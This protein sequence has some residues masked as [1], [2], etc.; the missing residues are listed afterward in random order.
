MRFFD[1]QASART[2]SRRLLLAFALAVAATVLA[3]HAA[4]WLVWGGLSILLLGRPAYPTLFTEV[5]LALALL[6]VLGGWWLEVSLLGQSAEKLARRLG[7]RELR[8]NVDFAEQRLANV[9]REMA[10]AAQMRPPRVMLLPRV[11]EINA[12]AL[13]RQPADWLVVVSAGALEWLSRRELQGLVAHEL[14]HLKEDDTR[15][16]LQLAG[17]VGGLEMV[18]NYGGWVVDKSLPDNGAGHSQGVHLWH[19]WLIG[20]VIQAAGWVG[21][22]IG[23]L[24][25]AAVSREREYL[26]DA[27]AVQWTRD[28]EGL[29]GVLRKAWAQH[30]ARSVP[31]NGRVPS[32]GPGWAP[33][34]HLL[35]LDVDARDANRWQHW[36]ASHPSLQ[37]RIRRLYGRPRGPLP[38]VRMDAR[39]GEPSAHQGHM[40]QG[41]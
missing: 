28:V 5:N 20:H 17:M 14:S 8:P 27:R 3:V 11:Q 24:L 1:H 40:P 34:H 7:A 26:A 25:Q 29:G 39:T 38:L 32:R 23:R 13:G 22:L 16:N 31:P 2:R 12:L 41:W 19:F 6:L 18:H 10:I 37:E 35:L 9:V 15:I 33:L 30:E 4:L 36:L 21:W